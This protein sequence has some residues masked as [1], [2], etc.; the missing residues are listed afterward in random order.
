MKYLLLLFTLSSVANITLFAQT[1]IVDV[2]SQMLLGFHSNGFQYAVDENYKYCNKAI[3]Y[4][5]FSLTGKISTVNGSDAEVYNPNCSDAY[6]VTLKAPKNIPEECIAIGGLSWDAQ[7]R[8]ISELS[9]SL[10][11]FKEVTA[12]ILLKEKMINSKIL[13]NKIFQVDIDGNGKDEVIVVSDNY[14]LI[15]PT[16]PKE[17]MYSIIFI[18][19][20][21]ESGEVETI[22]LEKEIHSKV[23][24]E[25]T[26][27]P[28][29][30]SLLGIL[31]LDNDG[32]YEFI[33]NAAY[34]EG[35]SIIVYKL[36][37]NKLKV[38]LST[39]CGA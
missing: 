38:V 32:K 36:V 31:D 30:Y 26:Q 20:M 4:T 15:I 11:S 18:R 21:N 25:D 35:N 2:P 9:T 14:P 37:G 8:K 39:G 24:E 34:Y 3:S 23:G 22:F 33:T 12:Q 7:P 10:K 13:I 27:P 1:P 19:S 16:I 17:G 6:S 5:L 29:L 28:V